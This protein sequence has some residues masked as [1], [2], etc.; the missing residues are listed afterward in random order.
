M[1]SSPS[2][3]SRHTANK[4]PLLRKLIM[5]LVQ[6][7]RSHVFFCSDAAIV[8]DP[9]KPVRIYFKAGIKHAPGI[10]EIEDTILVKLLIKQPD[11]F[12]AFSA[13]KPR[14]T[15]AHRIRTLVPHANLTY[16]FRQLVRRRAVSETANNIRKHRA[17]DT[18]IRTITENRKKVLYGVRH[19]DFKVVVPDKNVVAC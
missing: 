3:P 14:G 6:H 18:G 19:N 15:G 8:V 16:F 9:H 10:V 13:D 12:Y 17:D 7:L 1:K 4:P 11:R 2:A 5:H